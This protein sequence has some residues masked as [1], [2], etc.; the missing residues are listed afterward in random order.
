MKDTDL[1]G[2]ANRIR[3]ELNELERVLGRVSEGWRRARHSED[4]YYRG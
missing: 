3:L 2:L 4:D 1:S